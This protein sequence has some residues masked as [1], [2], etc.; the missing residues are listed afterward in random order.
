MNFI[1]VFMS[2]QRHYVLNNIIT[3]LLKL[4]WTNLDLI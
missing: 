1:I 4:E 3:K 2:K